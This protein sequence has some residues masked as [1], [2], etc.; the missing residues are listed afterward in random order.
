MFQK[1][2][3]NILRKPIKIRKSFDISLLK[4]CTEHIEFFAEIIKEKGGDIIDNLC[5]HMSHKYLKEGDIVFKEGILIDFNKI[6][7]FNNKNNIH[8]CKVVLDQL[9]L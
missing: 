8:L 2:A 7:F 5:L 6:N 9:S 1:L 4:K 3:I